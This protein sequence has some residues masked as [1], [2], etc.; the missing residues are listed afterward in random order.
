MNTARLGRRFRRLGETNS[1]FDLCRCADL[2]CRLGKLNSQVLSYRAPGPTRLTHPLGPMTR[3]SVGVLLTAPSTARADVGRS[4]RAWA[5]RD[6]TAIAQ[7]R[8]PRC[9]SPD[10]AAGAFSAP[11]P[12]LPAQH[13]EECCSARRSLGDGLA[14]AP[15]SSLGETRLLCRSQAR[16]SRFFSVSISAAYL[17]PVVVTEG[18]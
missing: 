1:C 6:R 16:C 15:R 5:L 10:R 8:V 18:C 2:F 4:A 3:A 13:L 17:P 14:M 12:A 11:A 9:G 7:R